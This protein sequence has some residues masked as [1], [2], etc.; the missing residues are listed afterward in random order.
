[1]F[2]YKSR[3]EYYKSKAAEGKYISEEDDDG[4][5]LCLNEGVEL[6]WGFEAIS[7]NLAI[8]YFNQD[9]EVFGLDYD[10]VESLILDLED[11]D[12][13]EMFVMEK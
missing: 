8:K 11:F 4:S 3:E 7:R 5:V 1:M 6:W 10:G 12:N 9:I 13:F 2:D